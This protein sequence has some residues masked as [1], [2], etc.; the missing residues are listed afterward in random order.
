[1]PVIPWE[2]SRDFEEFVAS[3]EAGFILKHS[4]RCPVSSEAKKEFEAFAEDSPDIPA[5][6]VLVVENRATSNAVTQELDVKHASPQA[7]LVQSGKATWNASH[8]D[9]TAANLKSAWEAVTAS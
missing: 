5:F 6:L 3:G 8:W 1:M 7:I 9:V 4:T 2:S